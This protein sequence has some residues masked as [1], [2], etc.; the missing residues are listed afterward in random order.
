MWY[1]GDSCMLPLLVI[2]VC[3]Y[4]FA[5]LQGKTHKRTMQPLPYMV[6]PVPSKWLWDIPQ[7]LLFLDRFINI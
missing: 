4:L 6:I 2:A 1:R 3:T 5:D 7:L